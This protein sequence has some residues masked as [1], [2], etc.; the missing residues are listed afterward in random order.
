MTSRIGR[1][2]HLETAMTKRC[3]FATFVIVFS[4]RCF[5]AID[6]IIPLPKEI[7]AVGEPL[8]LDGFRIVA[9]DDERSLIGAAEINQRIVS[10]G[11]QPLPVVRLSGRLPDGKWIVVA[12]CTAKEL[13]AV[14]PPLRVTSADPGPQGYVIQPSGSGESLKLLLVGSDSLG[15]LYAAVTFRQLII[16]QEGRL[17]LQP[18][19]VRDWPDFRTRCNG[20]PFSE[21]LRGD[22][23]GILSAEAKGDL[24]KARES[25]DR[26]VA[27]QKRHFD[28]L[29]RAKINMAWNRT[30]I[31]PGDAR[32]HTTV[33][34][35]ALSE[36]HEYG[37]KRGIAA[38]DADTT[39]IGRFPQ[40][41][42]NADFNSCVLSRSHGKYF[43]WSRLDY[44]QRRA[45]RAAR[46]LADCGYK[47]YYLHATDSGGW[48][49]PALWDDRCDQCRKNYGDDH[50]KADAAVF[51]IYYRA[52]KQQIPDARFVAVVYPY[53]GRYL[54]PEY[55]Y[56]NA[57]ATMGQGNPARMLAARTS[58]KLT[59]F[60][61]QLDSLLPPDI[62]ICIRESERKH[63][64]LARQAWGRRPFYLYYEYAF[65]K[66]WR[67][68]YLATPLMTRSLYY[69]AYDDILF[70]NVS[71]HGWRELTQLQ[72]VECAWNVN[73]PGAADFDSAVWHDCGTIS[74]ETHPCLSSVERQAFAR[75]ACRF[76]F[77]EQAG[78]L[79][80]P[81]FAE[82][83]SHHYVCFPEEVLDQVRLDDPVRTMQEQ[84]LAAGRAATS[85]DELWALQ[86]QSPVLS[87]DE[88]GYF[89][90][91]Y[92]MTHAARI[93]A[94]HRAAMMAVQRAIRQGD[95]S[96]AARQLTTARTLLDREAPAWSA[97]NK[98]I[99]QQQRLASPTRKT[100][101]AG[102]LSTLDPAEL[103]KEVDDL[104]ARMDELIAAHTI[105]G[106]FERDCRKRELIAVRAMEPV[107]VDGRLD[108]P[109][110]NNAPRIEHFVDCRKLRLESLE[111]VGRL[112]YDAG[113]LYVAMEC[114]DPNP[115]EIV[116]AMPAADQYRLCDSVEVLVAPRAGSA[117]S[118]HWIIDSRGTVF[119][120]RTEKA[121][122]GRT[123]YT[124][125]WNGTAQVNVSRA[126]D[127]W[128][129]ELAIPR[130]DVAV[131]LEPGGTA[132]V[133]L[134][135][136]IIHTRPE[137]EHEQNAVVFLDGDKFQTV[138]KFATLRFAGA[139]A[140]SP[141]AQVDVTLRPVTFGHE[142]IGDGSGTYFGGDLV[143]ETDTNLHDVRITAEYSDGVRP[144]GSVEIGAAPLVQLR[145]SPKQA[146][147]IAVPI[148]VPGVACTFVVDSREGV[149]R[150]ERRFGN[151]RRPDVPADRLF[152]PGVA[153][154]AVAM[155]VHF[156][157]LDPP[158]LNVE[159]GTIEFWVQPAWDVVPRAAGP[160]GSLEHALL[161][162]GP[163]RPD[164]LYLSNH[165]SL[166][167]SHVSSGNLSAILS[168]PSYESRSV[169]A[170]IRDW[171][172]G[173]WH[174]VALQWKLD[175]G[176]RTAMA[177]YVDG[178][179]ASD[180]CLG[181]AKHP[182]DQPL[183]MKP[184]PYPV[185][186]G[187]M[188]T[189]YRPADA[190]IDGLRIS[191]VRRYSDSFVPPRRPDADSA[192]L[193]LFHFDGSLGAET[194]ANCQAVP[195]PVQ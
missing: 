13:A 178:R 37:W 76:W 11:G 159:E 142:T 174:H 166:T 124:P 62:A 119:D 129:A 84:S 186:V 7:R 63:L 136:N 71:G 130:A 12:P 190:L 30:S 10:L 68:Y 97:F 195:G 184:L 90:N 34:R 25:A 32:D 122:D 26:W 123:V 72:G 164:H 127:R 39:S 131:P 167:V 104:A 151:P 38:I 3:L 18:A 28:W 138:E 109:A 29:L 175:D 51:G 150:I 183:K 108:E 65:W 152:A 126:A 121:D 52:I 110:W 15:T 64:D 139:E 88:Y 143:L 33:A 67:P 96:E 55:V 105:P 57:A 101:T 158:K 149:W 53:T 91:L 168:N 98:Q 145:W 31:D 193:A 73:R 82:N 134:C 61:Q 157:S 120:A 133:L 56:G 172:A 118:V 8:P 188:N 16:Q 155:P 77:G 20:A 87:G 160:R 182:N 21:H 89:L 128:T 93:L 66:G 54:D 46:W 2:K 35:A 100:S 45:E 141:E 83:I 48:S 194:P 117:Q 24:G 19:A 180:R 170:S 85:L 156:S 185:Q 70:G 113:T 147:R 4:A 74:S 36:V 115:S 50:A 154:Q 49:N 163:V 116:T 146:L 187:A 161:N 111:T 59:S 112:A 144:L 192:T 173:Q 5:A 179:L 22:W 6:T 81:V 189:G 69:P 41:R 106:W 79:V 181:S 42:D 132:R 176:G 80:A 43:C 165:S 58:E 125:K 137:G 92:Q 9:A 27:A 107:A 23:Y 148:E 114:F 60:L 17:L 169:D 162:I 191:S 135:R 44:H 171:Q 94:G 86:R 47:G 40:D 177:L 103:R 14:T 75:R 78:P 153:G 140:P 95:R 99:P 1:W 102:L